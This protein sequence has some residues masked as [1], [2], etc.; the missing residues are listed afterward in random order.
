MDVESV[1]CLKA[2]KVSEIGRKW[3]QDIAHTL[4]AQAGVFCCHLTTKGL[5]LPFL[6]SCLLMRLGGLPFWLAPAA[7][8]V[9]CQGAM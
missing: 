2:P 4:Q 9:G 1:P 3:A 8:K 5:H 7:S 6:L